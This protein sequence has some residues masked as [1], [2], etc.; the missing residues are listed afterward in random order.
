[1]Y[2]L[3][4]KTHGRELKNKNNYMY[5]SEQRVFVTKHRRMSRPLISL[6]E[7]R[8]IFSHEWH[9]PAVSYRTARSIW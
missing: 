5:V 2:K 7:P 4:I 3:N 6:E 9:K 1:M 8:G